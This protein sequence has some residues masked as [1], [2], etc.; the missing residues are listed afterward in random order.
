MSYPFGFAEFTP[1]PRSTVCVSGA[2]CHC[3]CECVSLKKITVGRV[4]KII[5]DFNTISADGDGLNS[6][7]FLLQLPTQILA[8]SCDC[9]V[10]E[11]FLDM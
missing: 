7:A 9:V 3:L 2:S 4:N 1:R 5:L 10:F 8:S 11:C 6:A